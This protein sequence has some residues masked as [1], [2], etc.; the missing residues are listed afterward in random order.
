M[1][2]KA[3]CS[4]P[5]SG[6][7]R[8][9]DVTTASSIMRLILARHGNTFE[10]GDKALW[11]GRKEDLPLAQEGEQQ[12]KVLADALKSA[13]IHPAAVYCGPLM[14]TRRFASIVVEELDL[15]LAPIEDDRLTEIDYG[16]WGGLTNE[17]VIQRYGTDPVLAWQTES[18]WPT[19]AG[20]QPGEDAVIERIDSLVSHVLKRHAAS[21]AILFVSSNGVLRYFLKLAPGLFERQQRSG[22]LKVATGQVCLLSHGAGGFEVERWDSDPRTAFA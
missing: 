8:W 5:I 18:R 4:T 22:G 15:R 2:L 10:P 16:A 9:P 11:V 14:R 12:A 13:G 3:S 6:F 1:P 17:Q 21:E 19:G 7:G 20:W